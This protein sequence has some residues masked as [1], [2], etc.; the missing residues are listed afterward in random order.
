MT[1][2]EVTMSLQQISEAVHT[3]ADQ[4]KSGI[5]ESASLG[6]LTETLKGIVNSYKTA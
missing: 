2:R 3:A 1:T 5:Q 6:D 4:A